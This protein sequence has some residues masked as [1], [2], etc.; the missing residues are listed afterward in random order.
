MVSKARDLDGVPRRLWSEVLA[1]AS[2][3]ERQGILVVEGPTDMRILDG[4]TQVPGPHTPALRGLRIVSV[5]EIDWQ[6]SFSGAS[7]L[8]NRARGIHLARERGSYFSSFE[9]PVRVLID[10]DLDVQVD[11]EGV[12]STDGPAIESYFV[13]DHGIWSLVSRLSMNDAARQDLHDELVGLLM[14][15]MPPLLRARRIHAEEPQE[16]FVEPERYGKF[17]RYEDG[18]W[19]VDVQ[20]LADMIRASHRVGDVDGDGAAARLDDA[21]YSAYGHDVAA[22][23][24]RRVSRW[25]DRPAGY[26]TRGQLEYWI[27]GHLATCLTCMGRFLDRLID[28]FP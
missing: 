16:S 10:L 3:T 17:I 11:I 18:E 7:I 25:K 26:G 27:Q 24:W 22:V 21:L 12:L 5:E 6:R 28:T 9:G 15:S 20:K 1:E 13:H 19:I 14:R 8:G 4:L 23:L 2:L